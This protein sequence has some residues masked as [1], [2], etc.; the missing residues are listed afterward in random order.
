[1]DL[2]PIVTMGLIL[3]VYRNCFNI[4]PFLSSFVLL[5]SHIPHIYMLQAQQF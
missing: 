4:A 5:L 2:I 3:A 1:M